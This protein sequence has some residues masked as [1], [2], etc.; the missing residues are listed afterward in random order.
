MAVRRADDL[1]VRA[2]EALPALVLVDMNSDSRIGPPP[3][4]AVRTAPAT[5]TVPVVAFG[6]HVDVTA[7]ALARTAGANRVLSNQRFLEALPD[8]MARY[9]G[10]AGTQAEGQA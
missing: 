3:C 7:Q 8:S 9:V 2:A 6:P 4:G 1:P 5:T 10:G